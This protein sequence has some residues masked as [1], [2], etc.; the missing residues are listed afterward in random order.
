RPLA[1]RRCPR[2]DAV[3]PL[4]S[5]ETTP[6][7]TKMCFVSATT[8]FHSTSRIV[9][10]APQGPPPASAAGSRPARRGLGAALLQQ[11]PGVGQ[12]DHGVTATHHPCDLP[13]AFVAVDDP[14]VARRHLRV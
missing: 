5:E 7:V 10:R 8:G 3:S 2:L 11:L 13:E 1:R 14:H 9:V 4:P 6:P 12:P